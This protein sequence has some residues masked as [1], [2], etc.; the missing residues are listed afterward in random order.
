MGGKG[1]E[2]EGRERRGDPLLSRYTPSRYILDKGL[3]EVIE[4][5]LS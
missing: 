4:I 1:K 2:G 5:H 3:R